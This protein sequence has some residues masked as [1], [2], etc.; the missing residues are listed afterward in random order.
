MSLWDPHYVALV[1]L[2]LALSAWVGGPPREWHQELAS[3]FGILAFSM[4]LVEFGLSGRF[5]AVSNG[6][7]LDVTMRF[8]Q[9]MARTVLVFAFLHPLFY[10][11][12][13]TAGP[14]PWDP[15]R[16]LTITNDFSALSTGILAYLLLGGL[17]IL[18]F[19]AWTGC[20]SD[21]IVVAASHVGGWA[22]WFASGDGLGMGCHD[23]AGGWLIARG[24][25]RCPAPAKGPAL[26]SLLCGSADASAVGS[27]GRA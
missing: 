3:G 26:A 17:A 13:P 10:Q 23:G 19:A 20:P 21:R 2:P 1:L 27:D 14:R 11:G 22:V 16:A 12:T 8:H 15:T 5:K 6:V 9:V 7:G 25:S 18:A 24:L 4:L